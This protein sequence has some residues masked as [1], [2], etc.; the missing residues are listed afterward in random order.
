MARE[1]LDFFFVLAVEKKKMICYTHP[2]CNHCRDFTEWIITNVRSEDYAKITFEYQPD[3]VEY[4]PAIKGFGDVIGTK[5]CIK[6]LLKKFGTCVPEKPKT[7]SVE[8]NFQKLCSERK[9]VV[10]ASTV[11]QERT[12]PTL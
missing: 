7:T 9:P 10:T 8:D 11:L 3:D 12:L 1:H 4:V 5:Q 2:K 6:H